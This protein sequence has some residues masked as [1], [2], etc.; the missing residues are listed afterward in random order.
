MFTGS[1]HYRYQWKPAASARNARGFTV[2]RNRSA[3]ACYRVPRLTSPRALLRADCK[4]GT[5]YAKPTY[6]WTNIKSWIE[7][8]DESRGPHDW[9]CHRG[10]E[11]VHGIGNHARLGHDAGPS[12]EA[13]AF[14]HDLV[15]M[16][17]QHVQK[18]TA[19]RRSDGVAA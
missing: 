16:M 11:C 4:F 2:R 18:A 13:A 6:F 14:P 15:A 9:I 7:A 3:Q 1:R 17:A 8:L 19:D 12:C 5:P 10:H